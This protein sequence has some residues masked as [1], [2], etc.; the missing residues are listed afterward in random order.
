MGENL[1]FSSTPRP[2]F[3]DCKNIQGIRI[4]T[5]YTI[6]DLDDILTN[7]NAKVYTSFLFLSLLFLS[8]L[9]LSFLFLSLILSPGQVQA[10]LPSMHNELL[11]DYSRVPKGFTLVGERENKR[12]RARER[13]SEIEHMDIITSSY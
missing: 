3:G 6:Y 12:E 13:A 10:S 5:P 8:L 7:I 4:H 2:L 11:P 1:S 9:F